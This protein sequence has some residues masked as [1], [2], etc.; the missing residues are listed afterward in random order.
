MHLTRWLPGKDHAILN[1]NVQAVGGKGRHALQSQTSRQESRSQ[2]AVRRAEPHHGITESHA[3]AHFLDQRPSITHPTASELRV[4]A[5][6][7]K[8]ACNEH[9]VPVLGSSLKLSLERA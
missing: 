5:S 2:D 6:N 9:D 1:Q 7:Q 4:R 3:F 8:I